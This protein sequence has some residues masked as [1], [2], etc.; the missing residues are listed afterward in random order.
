MLL[1]DAGE[2]EGRKEEQAVAES[3]LGGMMVE[4]GWCMG[5]R[6]GRILSGSLTSDQATG[7]LLV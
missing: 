4:M 6:T 2:T 3:V 1:G 7:F 5:A